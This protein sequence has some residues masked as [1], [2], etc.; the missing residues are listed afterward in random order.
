MF[1]TDSF[2]PLNLAK[3]ELRRVVTRHTL[4]IGELEIYTVE[5][6]HNDAAQRLQGLAEKA[7]VDS[8][9]KNQLQPHTLSGK[10]W[11]MLGNLDSLDGIVSTIDEVAKVCCR[12]LNSPRS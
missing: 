7:L 10:I 11:R 9:I 12:F 2:F 6:E 8:G 4:N 3:L 5:I 1:C